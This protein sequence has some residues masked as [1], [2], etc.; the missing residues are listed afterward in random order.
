V[1]VAQATKSTAGSS[2]IR[3]RATGKSG[4]TL[5]IVMKKEK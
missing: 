2:R 1:S 4:E 3:S 5:E